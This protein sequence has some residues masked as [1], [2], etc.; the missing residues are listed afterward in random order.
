MQLDVLGAQAPNAVS[1]DTLQY[2][3]D[4]DLA[5]SSQTVAEA[6]RAL[7]SMKDQPSDKSTTAAPSGSSKKGTMPAGCQP[8]GCY[9]TTPFC[10]GNDDDCTSR[11]LKV[12]EYVTF[13]PACG[14]PCVTG[15]KVK[16]MW[17]GNSSHMAVG[18]ARAALKEAL[19]TLK[20]LRKK[21]ANASQNKEFYFT[22]VSHHEHHQ[23]RFFRQAEEDRAAAVRFA[24]KKALAN[25]TVV[26]ATRAMDDAQAGEKAATEAALN[27]T[28]LG[29]Q[30][31]QQKVSYKKKLVD[32]QETEHDALQELSKGRI[33]VDRAIANLAQAKR[34]A[35][36]DYGTKKREENMARALA[37]EGRHEADE[38]AVKVA[39]EKAYAASTLSSNSSGNS[40]GGSAQATTTAAPPR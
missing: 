2:D 13:D 23:D 24:K 22:N 27:N 26:R 6:E 4:T 19:N 34:D 38:L 40:S 3:V 33:E 31:R 39:M 9:G 7:M 12:Q 8:A 20:W 16:C 1:G 17:C 21:V 29:E 32:E 5:T 10:S 11:G 30:H 14:L 36:S 18:P 15:K 28:K 35:F 25:Q 37:A